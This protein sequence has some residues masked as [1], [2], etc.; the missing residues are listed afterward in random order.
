MMLNRDV[1]STTRIIWKPAASSRRR[2]PLAVRSRPLLMSSIYM[3]V[4]LPMIPLSSSGMTVST[5]SNAVPVVAA[6]RT[7]RRICRDA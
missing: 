5:S 2:Y 1:V 7:F 4:H 6:I 3:S